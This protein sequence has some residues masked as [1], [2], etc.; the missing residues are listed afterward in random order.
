MPF[1]QHL[2]MEG[3]PSEQIK[4][5]EEDLKA[6]KKARE[7]ITILT[8]N[9]NI[10]ESSIVYVT[11][12]INTLDSQI[13]QVKTE[14]VDAT[15]DSL[16]EKAAQLFKLATARSSRECDLKKSQANL[17]N[18]EKSIGSIPTEA[19]IKDLET[20]IATLKETI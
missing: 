14:I 4:K 18:I 12:E 13:N 20:T 10:A 15:V 11:E 19:M 9:K 1:K 3:S 2:S 5:H 6:W 17:T 8:C 7:N 16:V